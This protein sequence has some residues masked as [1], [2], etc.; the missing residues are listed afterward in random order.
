M[1]ADPVEGPR[2]D[3]GRRLQIRRE[4]LEWRRHEFRR[5]LRRCGM[6]S[7]RNEDGRLIRTRGALETAAS[8]T[9]HV[10]RQE[11]D[12]T[13]RKRDGRRIREVFEDARRQPSWQTTSAGR[14]SEKRQIRFIQSEEWKTHVGLHHTRGRVLRRVIEVDVESEESHAATFR[15]PTKSTS[16]KRCLDNRFGIIHLRARFLRQ[17][18]ERPQT[19][20]E[21]SPRSWGAASSSSDREE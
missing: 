14:V 2:A 18:D 10:S 15:S 12:E 5:Y 6:V 16:S 20:E 13:R 17:R 7:S 19:L 9:R 4:D 21:R 11:Y 1:V 8:W 3:H